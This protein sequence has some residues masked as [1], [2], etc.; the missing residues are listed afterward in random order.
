MSGSCHSH[1][2]LDQDQVLIL[3]PGQRAPVALQYH[4]QG[5]RGARSTEGPGGGPACERRPL[6]G[7]GRLVGPGPRGAPP[8]SHR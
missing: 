5:T 1:S 4:I 7:P 2:K 6:V 8:L 3:R